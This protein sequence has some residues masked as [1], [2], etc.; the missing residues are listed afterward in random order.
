[1]R[2]HTK[3]GV[4][5]TTPSSG[6]PQKMKYLTEPDLYRLIMASKLPERP[7]GQLYP[8]WQF[9]REWPRGSQIAQVLTHRCDG[10]RYACRR[11]GPRGA[12]TKAGTAAG[13]EAGAGASAEAGS[14]QVLVDPLKTIKEE[15]IKRE[16]NAEEAF[17]RFMNNQ[18][19]H[20]LNFEEPLT[21]DQ[22]KTLR[23]AFAEA[24]IKSV[25]KDMN[26]KVGLEYKFRSCRKRRFR[27][28]CFCG[29]RKY[30]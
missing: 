27:L 16:I 17:L 2:D 19:P 30:V 25:L 10:R 28:K 15:T 6:G 13:A 21:F 18:C 24:E 12:G 11:G 23:Q 14:A 29:A 20:L 5:L 8:P 4:V 22:L 7:S 26:N 3:G 1:M 9:A